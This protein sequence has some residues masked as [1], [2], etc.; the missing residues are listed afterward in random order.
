MRLFHDYMQLRKAFLHVAEGE[1]FPVT[2]AGV[3]ELFY[4]TQR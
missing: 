3:A 2:M 1:A 4:C